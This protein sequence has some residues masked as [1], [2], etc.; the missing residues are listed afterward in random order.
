MEVSS[1]QEKY[2]MRLKN[3]KFYIGTEK[4]YINIAI[5]NNIDKITKRG[6]K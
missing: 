4:L 3:R 1:E 6:E 5:N 2:K